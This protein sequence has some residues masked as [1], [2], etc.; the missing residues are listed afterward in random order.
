MTFDETTPLPRA[1]LTVAEFCRV[2]SIGR[3][4][5]Y[6]L[7][8]AGR[9]RIKKL[10]RRTLVPIDQVSALLEGLDERGSDQ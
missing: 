6:S 3:S 5:F 4:S 9:I 7:A 10:G 2:C 8:A 1:A